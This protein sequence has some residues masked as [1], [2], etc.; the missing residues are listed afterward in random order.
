M[1]KV[2]DSHGYLASGIIFLLAGIL[3]WPAGAIF[4]LPGVFLVTRHMVYRVAKIIGSERSRKKFVKCCYILTGTVAG[5]GLCLIAYGYFG[6]HRI[7]PTFDIRSLIVDGIIRMFVGGYIPVLGLMAVL[8]VKLAT[9]ACDV[10]I[11]NKNQ[12]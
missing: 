12:T 3:T 2:S 9:K 4:V 7:C 11:E 6:Y 10:N 5:F 1:D 8:A